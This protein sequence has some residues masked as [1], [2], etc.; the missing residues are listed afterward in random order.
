MRIAVLVKDVPDTYGTR[1]LDL[2]TG[3][4]DRAGEMVL[5]EIGERAVEAAL[6]VSAAA[7]GGTVEL[8]C[9]GPE[10]AETSL[11]RGLAMGADSAI[12]VSDDTLVG[13]DLGQ[14][15]EV[16]AAVAARDPYDLIVAGNLS[17]DGN[18]GVLPAMVAELL[19]LPQLTNL[20]EMS[21]AGGVLSATRAADDGTLSLEA[22][23]PAVVSVTEAFPEPR[24]P[25]FKGLMAAKKK[26]VERLSPSELGIDAGDFSHARSIMIEVA[27]RPP[28]EAG[29]VVTDDGTAARQLADYLVSHRLV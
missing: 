23:L 28:R 11:R 13:A 10:S 25:N 6:A 8:I 5:D 9:V 15:A 18:G 3:L 29:T 20:T 22:E 12:L 27:Q 7:G 16:I 24:Y 14:T 17:T 19:G 4:T 2:E 26:P 1:A 21:V